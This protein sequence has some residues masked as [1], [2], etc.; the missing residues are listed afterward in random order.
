MTIVTNLLSSPPFKKKINSLLTIPS[1]SPQTAGILLRIGYARTC[2]CIEGEVGG[3]G[4][5]DGSR[6]RR[7]IFVFYH[8]LKMPRQEEKRTLHLKGKYSPC[9]PIQVTHQSKA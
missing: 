7:V 6:K 3:G 9:N 1:S 5:I 4:G 2:V 8:H